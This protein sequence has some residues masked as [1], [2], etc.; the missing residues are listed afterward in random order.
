MNISRIAECR[1]TLRSVF[2]VIVVINLPSRADRRKEMSGELAKLGLS[3]EDGSVTLLPASSF[4]SP[5]GFATC[6]ARGCFD[7]HLRA[8]RLARDSHAKAVLILEDDC[9]FTRDAS[10]QVS[11]AFRELARHEWGIFY[12][13]HQSIAGNVQSLGSLL[14][15]ADPSAAIEAAH[16]I[17]IKGDAIDTLIRYLEAMV[18]REPGSPLGGP[19][20]VDGAYSWFRRAHPH[21][22]TYVADPQLGYQ[23]P[24]RTDIHALSIL[25]RTPVLRDIM[26]IARRFKRK[27]ARPE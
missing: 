14:A 19:M 22:V 5:G 4:D 3:F 18:A 7:S 15:I 26:A 25:D 17:G 8:L 16:C 20:H 10:D 2:D 13:G 24:S 1:E 6:G 27:L 21:I 9:D 12:G 23:R 11:R